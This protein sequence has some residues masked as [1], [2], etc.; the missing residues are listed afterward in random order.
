[1]TLPK[2]NTGLGP[3]KTSFFQ[4]LAIGTKIT[5][6]TIEIMVSTSLR[7]YNVPLLLMCLIV[8]LSATYTNLPFLAH[9]TSLTPYLA[10]LW[11]YPPPPL[12]L[13]LLP[14]CTL[15]SLSS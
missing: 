13:S 4:A 3:E 2:Q 10:V 9:L 11:S 1:M 14:C 8:I 6:G 15:H 12:S 5:R 7:L